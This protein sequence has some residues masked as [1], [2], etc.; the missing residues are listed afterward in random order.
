MTHPTRPDDARVPS[1]VRRPS[2]LAIAEWGMLAVSIAAGVFAW[3]I[4]IVHRGY[5]YDE[6]QRAHSVW[7][8]SLGLRPYVATFE[9][10][11]PYFALL[12][13]ILGSRPD[14]CDGLLALRIFATTG[15]LAFLA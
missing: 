5:D 15:N 8:A 10:H 7:L 13:P 11:P 12:T 3:G 6:V 4:G 14:P 9:V 2:F 1:P